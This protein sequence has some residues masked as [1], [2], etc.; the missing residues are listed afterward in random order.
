MDDTAVF[1]KEIS[2]KDA[3]RFEIEWTD[4]KRMDYR[5]SDLQKNCPCA[6]CRDEKTGAS[7]IDESKLKADVSAFRIKS[8]GRYALRIDFTSGCSKGIFTFSFLRQLK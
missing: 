6:R 8:M 7:L 5:L 3:S 1:V 4:G 2:Q